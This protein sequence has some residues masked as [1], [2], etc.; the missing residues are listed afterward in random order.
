MHFAAA[1]LATALPLLANGQAQ[2]LPAGEFEGRG[3][4]M[5]WTLDD[6]G[7]AALAAQL[8]QVTQRTPI[9]I[10]YEH[11]TLLA[12]SN[13][14]PA[15][16]A[17]WITSVEWRQGAGLFA[18]VNW[19][20]RAKAHIAANE[21]RYISPVILFDKE[22]RV[23]GLHNAA[24][25]SVPAIVGMEPVVAA[26]AAFS[27]QKPPAEK[28]PFMDRNQL[29]VAIGLTVAAT[30][31]QI[32]DRIAALVALEKAPKVPRAMTAALGL[33][34]GADEAV[35]LAALTKLKTPAPDTATLA[36]VTDLQGKLAALS[37][38]IAERDVAELVDGAIAAHKLMPAQRDWAV[39]LGKD[40]MA[41]LTAFVAAAPAIPGL[42]GQTGGQPRDGG[43]GGA[44]DPAETAR[45]ALAYQTAQ[46]AAGVQLSTQQAVDAVLA[47]TAK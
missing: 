36:Q 34:D 41:Q 1:L 31:K 27:S 30:D 19:T 32:T 29:I 20:E 40:N 28:G 47:G 4:G 38:Q 15:P 17:G 45:K 3:H 6:A 13:G 33:A 24:L 25:V 10:D 43:Q 11:Q 46:L 12:K 2:L 9:S 5:S 39:G 26:L 8:N 18:Q 44:A 14:Q 16:A 7:G 23:V 37:A 21:Y 22:R 35:A 42:A